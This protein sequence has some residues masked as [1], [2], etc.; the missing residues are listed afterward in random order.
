MCYSYYCTCL[1]LIIVYSGN[2]FRF[3]LFLK[4]L[5]QT[6]TIFLNNWSQNKIF[7]TVHSQMLCTAYICITT[8]IMYHLPRGRDMPLCVCS[9]LTCFINLLS[10]YG[11][12]GAVTEI[13]GACT[14]KTTGMKTITDLQVWLPGSHWNN[15]VLVDQ[16]SWLGLH[17]VTGYNFSLY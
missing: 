10:L 13:I 17:V 8:I 3:S 11:I 6:R 15:W 7:V 16:Y 9:L 14:S 12:C 1:V 5:F 2:W 4:C